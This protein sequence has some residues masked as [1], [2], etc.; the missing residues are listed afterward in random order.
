M[1]LGSQ[2]AAD[3]LSL[4][5]DRTAMA[6]NRPGTTRAVALDISKAFSRVCNTG[7]FHKLESHRVSGHI[8][9]LILSF[10]SSC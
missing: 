7:H 6:F 1:V 8:F 3:L 9:G 4:V 2:S 10:L 5:S